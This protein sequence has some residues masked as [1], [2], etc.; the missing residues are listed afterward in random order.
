MLYAKVSA[1]E[2]EAIC[3][4]MKT[5]KDAKMYRRLKV[6]DLSGQGHHVADLARL[7]D[8]SE[9]VVRRYI[10]R[11]NR[12]GFAGVS[13][14]YGRGRPPILAWSQAEWLDVLSQSPADLP[15]LESAARNWTQALLR[16]YLK[17]YHHI[18]VSQ[19]TIAKSLRNADIRWRRA[20][21]RVH[22]PDPL[23]QVKRQ[24]IAHLQQQALRGDLTSQESAHP[25]SDEPPQRARL[26]FL[27]S[28]DLHWCP[29]LGST[30]TSA[31]TQ[32]KV[33]SPGLENPW[34]ALFGS[35]VFPSGEGLYTIHQRKR[36]DE[37]LVHLE[38]LLEFDPDAFWFVV[39]DNASAHTTAAVQ[40]FAQRHQH[41]LELVYLPTYS[42]HLNLIERLWRLMRSQL[43]RNR[44][45][46]SLHALAQAATG[47]LE[48]LPFAHFCSLLGIDEN[49]LAFLEQPFE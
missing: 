21:L 12:A 14:H 13:P 24:R 49:Q 38:T 5:T 28:T 46:P 6:I 35:L 25:R 43:T 33:P 30:Y 48:T 10:H 2:R 22:S 16:Q 32:G 27:D 37:L 19:P 8:L 29:D 41:R 47:W 40:A 36:S 9:A 11:F 3:A 4:A 31:G 44:F 42:P 20:K 45:F 1:Q 34:F 18:E 23:Y 17:L 15:L 39:L 7:F 26:V